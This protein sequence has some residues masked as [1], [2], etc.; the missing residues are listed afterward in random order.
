MLESLDAFRAYCGEPTM[1]LEQCPIC[2]AIPERCWRDTMSSLV[3]ELEDYEGHDNV[4]PQMHQLETLMN[5]VGREALMRCPTCHRLYHGKSEFEHVGAQTYMT[6]TY[7]RTDAETLY[8]TE[9]CVSRRLAG[10][11]G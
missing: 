6:T 2:S 7:V 10:R 11:N 4:P 1:P 8:G 3:V 5:E 9:L